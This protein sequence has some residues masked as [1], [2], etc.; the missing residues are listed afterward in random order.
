MTNPEFTLIAV[1]IAIVAWWLW[2]RLPKRQVSRLA[3]KIRDPKARADLEDNFR[4]TVGQA[5]GGAAVLIGAAFAVF[6]RSKKRRKSSSKWR[7]INLLSSKKRRTT[8]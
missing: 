6:Q 1:F 2:W 4:K 8:F 5:L 7:K 3:L